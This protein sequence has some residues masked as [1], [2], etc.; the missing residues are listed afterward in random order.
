M[1]C[2]N[3]NTHR[4]AQHITQAST[5]APTDTPGVFLDANLFGD[6]ERED[7]DEAHDEE[8]EPLVRVPVVRYLALKGPRHRLIQRHTHWNTYRKHS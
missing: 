4:H 7:E 3:S 8:V 6:G 5:P 2:P 1:K